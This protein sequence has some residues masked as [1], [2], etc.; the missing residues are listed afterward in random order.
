MHADRGLFIELIRCKK[1]EPAVSAIKFAN[2]AKIDLFHVF[3]EGDFFIAL[4]FIYVNI[5]PE[6]LKKLGFYL[7]L[8][9]RRRMYCIGRIIKKCGQS[10]KINAI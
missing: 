6:N 1:V 7:K 9:A 5:L 8:A 2:N 10:N 3:Y 4:Y